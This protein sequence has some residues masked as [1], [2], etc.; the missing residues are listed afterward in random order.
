MKFLKKIFKQNKI[1][2]N[3][4]NNEIMEEGPIQY[5]PDILLEEILILLPATFLCKTVTLIS[6]RWKNIIENDLFWIEKNLRDKRLNRKVINYLNEKN[7][8]CPKKL[9]FNCIFNRNLLKNPSGYHGL[10]NWLNCSQEPRDRT[11][12]MDMI[13][14]YKE[15]QNNMNNASRVSN[16][17]VESEQNGAGSFLY[18]TDDSGK[19][20]KNFVTSYTK[21]HKYQIIELDQELMELI[22]PKIELKENWTERFDCGCQYFLSVLLVDSTFQIVD[23]FKFEKV[24]EQWSDARWKEVRHVFEVS[25]PFKYI[26]YYHA[27]KDTQFWAGNYGAKMTNGSVR[28]VI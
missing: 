1:D 18:N 15:A 22:K 28:I 3:N 14:R 23:W 21:G 6:K 2:I 25:K 11:N 19:M 16:F 24:R 13:Q 26:V 8:L 17:A 7:A 20:F 9:Y 27:G 5:L 12:V 4:N 10:A